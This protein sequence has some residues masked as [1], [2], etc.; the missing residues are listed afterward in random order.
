MHRIHMR[1]Y[2]GSHRFLLLDEG[3]SRHAVLNSSLGNEYNC[4]LQHPRSI[5]MQL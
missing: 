5:K 3:V 4:S 2:L 1:H